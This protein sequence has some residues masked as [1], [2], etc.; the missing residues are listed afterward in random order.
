MS[1]YASS[2]TLGSKERTVSDESIS[3]FS[4][5]LFNGISWELET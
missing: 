4:Q 3:S 1:Y 5:K 2:I